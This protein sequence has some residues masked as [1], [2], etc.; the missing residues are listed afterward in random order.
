MQCVDC[1][2]LSHYDETVNDYRHD[3]PTAPLCFAVRLT[4][5]AEC[6]R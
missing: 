3:D 4:E 1:G 5:G 2:I 6:A